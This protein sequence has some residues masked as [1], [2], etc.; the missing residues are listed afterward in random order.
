MLR[1]FKSLKNSL[2]QYIKRHIGDIGGAILRID[3]VPKAERLNFVIHLNPESNEKFAPFIDNIDLHQ[4]HFANEINYS[5][6][7]FVF[8]SHGKKHQSTKVKTKIQNVDKVIVVASGKGGV[9]KSTVAMI[10]ATKLVK[11]G[12]RVGFLDADIYGPSIPHLIDGVDI[13]PAIFDNQFIPHEVEGIEY[14]S[15]GF[16]LKDKAPIW[17]GPLLTK[18]LKQMLQARWNN[19]DYLIIDTPPGTGDIHLSLFENSINA[20]I[21]VSTPHKLSTIDVKKLI[22]LLDIMKIPIK[23]LVVNMAYAEA[24]NTKTYPFGKPAN[25]DIDINPSCQLPLNDSFA[26][27][28]AQNAGSIIDSLPPLQ[29]EQL[30]K[31]ISNL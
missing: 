25:M 18:A 10:I 2:F 16:L 5:S 23:G 1:N 31:I 24:G 9:G 22:N 12:Y 21:L 26:N 29:L 7:S 3:I 17:R 8:S 6:I 27:F 13:T 30:E 14:M 4:K 11:K 20:A 15:M 28:N 19:L